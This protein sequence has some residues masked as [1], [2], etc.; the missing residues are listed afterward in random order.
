MTAWLRRAG[1][2]G[3]L[4]CGV[5]LGG[6]LCGLGAAP[7]ARADNPMGFVRAGDW[8]DA[9]AAVADAADPVA[10]KLVLFYRLLAPGAATP[11]EISAFLA[12][13]PDW[14]DR[15][16]LERRRAEALVQDGDDADASA[17]C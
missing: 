13:N 5:L 4:W 9:T 1:A 6:L 12:A 16:L 10:R 3:A 2:T 8:A 15:W 14:P 11:D 7:A 17:N